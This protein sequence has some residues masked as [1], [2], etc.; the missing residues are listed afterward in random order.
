M[1]ALMMV[2]LSVWMGLAQADTALLI[3][4]ASKHSGCDKKNEKCFF[5][6]FNP[7]LGLE[8]SPAE[9][10]WG[11]PMVRAGSY[12]DSFSKAAYFLM[13]GARREWSVGGGVKVGLGIQAGYINGSGE[14]NGVGLLPILS[15]GYRRLALEVG[16][17]PVINDFGLERDV[18][19]T[20]FSLRWDLP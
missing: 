12:K 14:D 7:G 17:V 1:K 4:G 16:Y 8:W 13:A 6:E 3:F 15:I 2:C 9:Y 19:V 20:T 10:T 5:N 11:R 18:S